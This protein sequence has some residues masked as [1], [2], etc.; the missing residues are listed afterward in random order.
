[1]AERLTRR[2]NIRLFPSAWKMSIFPRL[3]TPNSYPHPGFICPKTARRCSSVDVHN[4]MHISPAYPFRVSGI[5]ADIVE[6]YR[7][8]SDEELQKHRAFRRVADEKPG[9]PCRVSLVDAEVGESVFLLN[10][11]HLPGL[12]PYRSVGPIFVRESATETYSKTNEIPEVLQVPGRLLSTRA[13]DDQ[14]LLVAAEAI[15]SAEIDQSI[16]RLF[17]NSGVA[18]IHVHN[19]CPGCYSCRIDRA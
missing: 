1:M 5:S 6:Q 14:D 16:Q 11:E 13:Y 12:S 15:G 4:Y 7:H 8:L 2:F 9:F 18:Y 19:A 10:F 17:A 3:V